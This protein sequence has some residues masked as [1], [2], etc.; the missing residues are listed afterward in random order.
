MVE[1]VHVVKLRDLEDIFSKYLGNTVRMV[2]N[3]LGDEPSDVIKLST[4]EF[5][6]PLFMEGLHHYDAQIKHDK[7]SGFMEGT[8]TEDDPYVFEEYQLHDM[9]YDACQLGLVEAGMYHITV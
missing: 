1:N 5:Q 4:V 2:E 6:D 7:R 3:L 9:L 8:G